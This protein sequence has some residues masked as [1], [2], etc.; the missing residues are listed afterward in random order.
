MDEDDADDR[1]AERDW[2]KDYYLRTVLGELI[3]DANGAPQ[4]N[5]NSPLYVEPTR[6][7][8][9]SPLDDEGLRAGESFDP[10]GTFDGEAYDRLRTDEDG[11]TIYYSSEMWDDGL[12]RATG[13]PP[14]KKRRK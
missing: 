5:R 9:G 13:E 1:S 6:F 3:P 11:R 8:N 10:D 2:S 14:V 4:I 7:H 12:D